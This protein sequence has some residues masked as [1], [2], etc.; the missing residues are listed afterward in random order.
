M[1]METMAYYIVF[2]MQRVNQAAAAVLV[3]HATGTDLDNLGAL[4]ALQRMPAETDDTF[5]VRIA[6]RLEAIVAGSTTW[7]RQQVVGL[8]VTEITGAENIIDTV[9]TPIFSNVKDAFIQRTPNPAYNQ[10]QPISETNLPDIPGSIDIYI[11][12]QQWLNPLTNHLTQVTPSDR[13]IQTVRNYTA[14]Q[15]ENE[16]DP[17]RK[18]EAE[19]RRF[20]CDTLNIHPAQVHPYIVCAMIHVATGLD[21]YE[22]LTNVQERA[23]RF[24]LEAEQV[25]QRI[26]F[27]EFYKVINSNEVTEVI[28]EYPTADIEPEANAVPVVFAEHILAVQQYEAF[29]SLPAF[30]S[31]S[32][33]GWTINSNTLYFRIPIDQQD[34]QFY[35]T[36]EPLTASASPGLTTWAS[37]RDS[38]S[39]PTG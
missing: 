13:M 23:R 26:P 24:V 29:S 39:I 38:P 18:Q 19:D 32:G 28:L 9:P 6:E 1:I 17:Q 4:F 27:S 2:M 20:I 14:A 35:F 8:Q 12:S 3:T 7:Y 30:A 33:T 21:P 34:H 16:T 36:S 37:Q 15:G 5:R 31:A 25:G 22:V 10:A 11:Q